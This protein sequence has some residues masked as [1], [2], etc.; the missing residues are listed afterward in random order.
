VVTG[1]AN[2]AA[3][4]LSVE[5]DGPGLVVGELPTKTS[6]TGKFTVRVLLGSGDTGIAS[7]KAYYDADGDANYNE[8]GDLTASYDLIVGVSATVA[9]GKTSV[10][11]TVKGAE[12]LTVKIVRGAKVSTKV[13]TSDNYKMTLKKIKAGKRSVKVYVSDIL[14]AS[15][16]VTVKK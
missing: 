4:D 14:V 11:T 1:V 5:Y 2:S 8:T 13:A 3:A 6:S 12:G 15:K 10:S 7:L 9:G 16:T